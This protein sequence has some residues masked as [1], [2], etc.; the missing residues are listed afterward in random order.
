MKIAIVG[1]GP[2]GFYAADSLLNAEAG[3]S[4]DMFEK[5][6]VPF[7]LVRSGVAP[8]HPKLKSVISQ[9]EEV[10]ANKSFR[11]FGNVNIG[12]DI[13]IDE[14]REAYSAV[15]IASGAQADRALGI[16]G[17]DLAG[18]HSARSFV[19][20]YNGH[21]DFREESFDLSSE[22]AVIVGLGNVAMDVCRILLKPV[23]EL[24]KTDIADH[25]LEALASSK[26]REVHIIG[27]RGPAQMKI[28]YKEMCEIAA[29]KNCTVNVADNGLALNAASKTEIES[30]SNRENSFNLKL[31]EAQADKSKDDSSRQ[32]V[33]HFLKRPVQL[34][35]DTQV[36][37]VQLGRNQLTGEAFAQSIVESSELEQ[38]SS[39]LV[40]RSVGY[41]SLPMPGVDFNDDKHCISHTNGRVRPGLYCTGWIKRGPSGVIGTN[42]ADSMETVAS[43]LEDVSSLPATNERAIHDLVRSLN[44][45][46]SKVVS[47]PD[48]QKIDAKEKALGEPYSRPRQKL[49]SVDD[50]LA[51]F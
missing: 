49:V 5:L 44:N 40:F 28:S 39:G 36:S 3:M 35:G 22:V 17:E 12:E 8:D 11:F 34:L 1:S 7:G 23:D 43:L 16:P 48:W 30:R 4:V 51:C 9:Y 45:R 33:F 41:K 47:Y 13:T 32:C 50:M 2:S 15:I 42:R 27:R 38:I 19:N 25:A 6:P 18:S 26:V 21:P 46:V 37:A 20:W 29:L 14:L 24:R 31:L 10:A